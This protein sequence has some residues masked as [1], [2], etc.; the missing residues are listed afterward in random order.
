MSEL[1]GPRKSTTE[2]HVSP[3]PPDFQERV[4]AAIAVKRP[5]VIAYIKEVRRTKPN[6]TPAETMKT[7]ESQYV[8]T[9]TIASSAIGA[10]SAIPAVG[11]PIAIGLGVADLL[12]FYEWTALTALCMA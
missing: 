7:I 1:R 6:A 11:I 3:L 4:F 12:F 9:T 8:A 10:S 2:P 5:A